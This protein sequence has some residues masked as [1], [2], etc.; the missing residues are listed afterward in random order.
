MA[1]AMCPNCS[2]LLVAANS[3]SFADL[4]TAVGAAKNFHTANTPVKAIS[5]SYGGADFQESGLGATDNYQIASR[6]G[7]A[8]LASSGDTGFGVESPASFTNVIGVGGTT[9]NLVGNTWSSE[10]VWSGAGS[11]CS[12][13]NLQVLPSVTGQL[14]QVASQATA[15]TGCTK[16]AISD[17]SA[18]ANPS[19]GVGVIYNN[20]NYIFGGT[21]VSSP[22]I[23]GMFAVST[24]TPSA[25]VYAASKLWR[26]VPGGYHD[27]M[28][29]TNL[30]SCAASNKLCRAATGWDGP[31]G[32]GT[33][34]SLAV[35]Q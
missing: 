16:K 23:A 26:S 27:I 25:T 11:G 2:I 1:T 19:T 30:A 20:L 4:N 15:T 28:T 12:T 13:L 18:V 35:F 14:A 5:N 10:T 22:L 32:F 8:V 7:I 3:A 6:M 34:T 9:L 29:G 24:F 17:I 33:P 21:S 31:T